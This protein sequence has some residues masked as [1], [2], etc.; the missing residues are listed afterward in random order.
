[1]KA[2]IKGYFCSD[3]ED[4]ETWRPSRNEEFY[5]GLELSIGEVGKEGADLFQVV[6]ATPE[7]VQGGPER[8]R[9][10]MLIVQKYSWEE[11]RTIL[12]D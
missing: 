3:R 5:L 12:E 8:R 2:E 11:V 7:A 9:S 1:M 4:F 6:I 10:K